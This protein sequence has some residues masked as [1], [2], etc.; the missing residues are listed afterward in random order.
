MIGPLCLR[1]SGCLT[2]CGGRKWRQKAEAKGNACV[3]ERKVGVNASLPVA[4]LGSCLRL[5]SSIQDF[6]WRNVVAIETDAYAGEQ[7]CR[8]CTSV[9]HY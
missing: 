3:I 4:K 6:G 5:G 8:L 1:I 7:T 2:F 9:S